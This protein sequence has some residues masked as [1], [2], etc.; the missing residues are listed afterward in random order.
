MRVVVEGKDIL[1]PKHTSASTAFYV[2]AEFGSQKRKTKTIKNS[3]E[4]SWGETF[5]LYVHPQEDL[6]PA[7]FSLSL[8]AK[9]RQSAK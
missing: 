1:P 4:P 2:T 8:L 7:Q 3:L 5:D 6:S 9:P